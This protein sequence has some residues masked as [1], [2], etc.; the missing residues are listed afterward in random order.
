MPLAAGVTQYAHAQ[1]TGIT[2]MPRNLI[3]AVI[4][5]TVALLMRED[6]SAEEPASGFGPAARTTDEGRGGAAAGLV[7]DAENWLDKYRPVWR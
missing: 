3:Q 7:N 4:A 2:G 1:N 6:V 5:L